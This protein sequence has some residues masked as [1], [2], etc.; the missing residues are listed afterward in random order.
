MAVVINGSGTVSGL[1]AQAS[2]IE[3]TDN[4]K[5]MVGTSDDLEIYHD[6]SNSI[7]H[8][9]GTGNLLL[10]GDNL[11]LRSSSN[12][13]YVT[14]VA[15]GEVSI[16]HNN[17]VKLATTATGVT[18]TGALGATT[19]TGDGSALTGLIAGTDAFCAGSDS[20]WVAVNDDNI[21]IMDKD[22]GDGNYDTDSTYNDST[23][24]FTASTT[25][26]Y[27]FWYSVLTGQSDSSNGFGFLKNSS[28]LRMT[29]STNAH[30]SLHESDSGDHIQTGFVITPL[31]TD[32][33]MALCATSD[34][35]Y[36]GQKC[37]WGGCRLK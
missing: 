29:E 34:G 8:D 23:Y 9:N 27:M 3:L 21:L 11:S 19:L 18:V 25:G 24:K 13:S 7:I 12:E 30:F 26:V 37:S 15:N 17:A 35:D 2:D 10:K 33:T 1:T 36:Y 32:D 28:K 31:G 20:T 16:Y 22:S 6:G 14:G 4:T 5:I